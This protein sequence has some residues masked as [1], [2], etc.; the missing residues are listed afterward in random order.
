MKSDIDKCLLITFKET[1]QYLARFIIHV[2]LTL[3]GKK[4]GEI[5]NILFDRCFQRGRELDRMIKNIN[6][7]H[8]HTFVVY[9]CTPY[10]MYT[11][12]YV[13]LYIKF[14]YS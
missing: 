13:H 14:E 3:E 4:K 8:V 5:K 6:H 7:E 12:R 11:I 9:V 1:G 2:L 10:L